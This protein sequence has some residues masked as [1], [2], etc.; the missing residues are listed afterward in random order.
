MNEEEIDNPSL[1]LHGVTVTWCGWIDWHDAIESFNRLFRAIEQTLDVKSTKKTRLSREK[2]TK[3]LAVSQRLLR[4][5]S[6]DRRPIREVTDY[7]G[8]FRGVV[9]ASHSMYELVS[10][11]GVRL[12][13]SMNPIHDNQIEAIDRPI[14]FE[15][16]TGDKYSFIHG[17]Y[18]PVTELI[19]V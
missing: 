17:I 3:S 5:V 19:G 11:E 8:E 15:K 1:W 12:P 9:V 6:E 13:A 18:T 7:S 4:K 2:L 16:L 10:S 14:W